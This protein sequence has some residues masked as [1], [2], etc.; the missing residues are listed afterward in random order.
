MKIKNLRYVKTRSSSP[1]LLVQ[2]ASMMQHPFLTNALASMMAIFFYARVFILSAPGPSWALGPWG[3]ASG[4]LGPW[5]ITWA[6][7]CWRLSETAHYDL[8]RVPWPVLCFEELYTE[9][10]FGLQGF[11]ALD[12]LPV[13]RTIRLRPSAEWRPAPSRT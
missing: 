3:R 11:H 7:L 5:A 9:S 6:I 2:L 10:R 1:T 13:M 4:P 8:V 12:K